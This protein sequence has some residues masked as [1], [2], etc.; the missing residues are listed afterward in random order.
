[1]SRKDEKF[2]N[3]LYQK[4]IYLANIDT[5]IYKTKVVKINTFVKNF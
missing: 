3:F 1:M 4:G 5:G 2:E